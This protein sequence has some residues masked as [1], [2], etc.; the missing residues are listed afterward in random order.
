MKNDYHPIILAIFVPDLKN[1]G[2]ISN[3]K[4]FGIC[5]GMFFVSLCTTILFR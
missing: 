4:V 1:K 2:N 3:L 5:I